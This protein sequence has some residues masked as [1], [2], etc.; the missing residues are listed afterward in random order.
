MQMANTLNDLHREYRSMTF[1]SERL[2]RT[3]QKVMPG[4]D[5]RSSTFFVPYPATIMSASGARVVDADDNELID[6]LNNY[7]ALVLG[8]Q[9]PAVMTAVANQLK[10]GTAFAA[11]HPS[12]TELG[13]YIIN[14]IP[15]AERIRFCNSGTEAAM[16]GVRL[17]RE[18][19][20]RQIIVKAYGGYHGTFN[21]LPQWAIGQQHPVSAGQ[22]SWP[23][24]AGLINDH[25]A[26]VPFDDIQELEH[27]IEGIR[28]QVAAVI[29]EPVLGSAGVFKA[30]SE[31]LH[32]VRK[33]CDNVGALMILDEVMTFRLSAG[34]AQT[35]YDVHP[36]LTLLG[37]II[38]GGYPVGAFT[39]REE[40]LGLLDP[41]KQTALSHSG[42]YNGNPITMAAGSATL[43]TLSDQAYR[44]LDTLGSRVEQGIREIITAHS[45]PVGITRAGSLLQLHTTPAPMPPT[46]G[47]RNDEKAL[48]ALH[49]A[50]YIEGIYCAPRGYFN[51]SLAHSDRDVSE[52]IH[53]FEAALGRTARLLADASYDSC[54]SISPE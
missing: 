37:K 43:R 19:T 34:G 48:N 13:G 14:R 36:D 8:H 12:Q 23:L 32:G 41:T 26:V 18:F 28:D 5:T 44:R 54:T 35:L 47:M 10:E 22:D 50:L 27:L 9:H 51:M 6:C 21:E 31:Y 46:P 39:G 25:V 17:A 2:W 45:L 42:T 4:G 1:N 15:A 38:G 40:I 29:L 20:G 30:S 53:S 33:L 11:P 16:W 49:L 3:A 52:I 7:S 24:I